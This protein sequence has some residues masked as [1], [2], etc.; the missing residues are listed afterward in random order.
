M[1]LQIGEGL[2][3]I[4]EKNEEEVEVG[5]LF[6]NIGHSVVQVVRHHHHEEMVQ[7]L[8]LHKDARQG[9]APQKG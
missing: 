5:D 9:W 8:V 7:K 2:E 3:A 1:L 6:K 4:V